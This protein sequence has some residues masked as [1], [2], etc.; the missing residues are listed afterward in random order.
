MLEI[1][2]VQTAVFEPHINHR[3][4]NVTKT[5]YQIKTKRHISSL[6]ED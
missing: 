4:T 6:L 1:D 3:K 5:R 2:N